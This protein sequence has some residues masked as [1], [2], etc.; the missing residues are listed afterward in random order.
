MDLHISRMSNLCLLLQFEQLNNDQMK[1]AE[2]HANRCH[3]PNNLWSTIVSRAVASKPEI[4]AAEQH[5]VHTLHSSR[6]SP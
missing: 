6:L 2:T 3:Q 5:A 1:Q 4:R